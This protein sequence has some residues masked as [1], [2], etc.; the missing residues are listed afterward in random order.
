VFTTIYSGRQGH[1]PHWQNRLSPTDIRILALYV[2]TLAEG[3]R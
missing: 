2:G 3:D 1:M